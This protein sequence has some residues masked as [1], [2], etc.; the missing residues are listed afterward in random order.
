MD[1]IC[2]LCT[3][4][5]TMI[6]N[7][8]YKVAISWTYDDPKTGKSYGSIVKYLP[9]FESSFQYAKENVDDTHWVTLFTNDPTSFVT[10]AK[11]HKN[12]TIKYQ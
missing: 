9:D 1:K 6:N 8:Y 10:N 7:Y 2:P 11:V 4:K 5:E 3:V 12:L